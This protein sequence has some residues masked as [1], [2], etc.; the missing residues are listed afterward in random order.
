ML[1]LNAPSANGLSSISN[2]TSSPTGHSWL[3]NENRS[4]M[5][6]V[7]FLFSFFTNFPSFIISVNDKLF[8]MTEVPFFALADSLLATF[9]EL[10]FRN[11]SCFY[12][13]SRNVL[14]N[15]LYILH[16]SLMPLLEL[17]HGEILHWD[18]E[19]LPY[20]F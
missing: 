6:F 3:V 19:S 8:G 5:T 2:I 4:T 20:W 12:V 14:R 7:I 9:G 17:S 13:E 1:L 11:V 15:I 10:C 16:T 18:L